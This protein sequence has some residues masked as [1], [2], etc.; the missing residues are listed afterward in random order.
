VQLEASDSLTA[1]LTGICGLFS[2]WFLLVF[3]PRELMLCVLLTKIIFSNI[4][5][6]TTHLRER[7]NQ[8]FEKENV[9]N[10]RPD[11]A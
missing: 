11:D 3:F 10:N 1:K 9:C 7:K 6:V 4:S 8:P 2:G 5:N